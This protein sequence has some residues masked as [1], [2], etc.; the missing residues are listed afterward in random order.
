MAHVGLDGKWLMVNRRL[1]E[2]LGYEEKEMLELS[3]QDVTYPADLNADVAHVE[4]LIAGEIETYSMEKRYVRKDGRIVWV[5]LTVSLAR[6][7]LALGQTGYFISV[8]EDITERKRTDEKLRLRDRAIAAS[9]NGIVIADATRLDHPLTYVN[10]A[11][12][13]IT[14]YAPDEVLGRNCRFL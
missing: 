12:E 10:P 6:E 11:F 5:E 8:V 4:E 3:F 2:I 14:G 1:C 7:G 13:A 9:S